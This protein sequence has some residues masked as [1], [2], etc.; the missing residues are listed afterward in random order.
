MRPLLS[1]YDSPRTYRF[2]FP[3]GK[4]TEEKSYF[5]PVY[6]RHKGE[7]GHDVGLFPFFWGES[8]EKS[9][10][11]VFPVYGKLYNRYRRDEIGFFLWPLYGYSIGDGTTR[12]NVV[13]PLFSF[14]KGHQE[15]FKIGPL[16]GAA[17]MGRRKKIDLCPLALLYQG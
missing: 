2:L 8:G 1:T 13:W 11:G 4:S 9:Y 14:Y 6:T 12:T 15:G 3:L 5:F 16:Y 10:G 17:D 7:D